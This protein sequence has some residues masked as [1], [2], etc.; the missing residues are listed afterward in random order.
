[1]SA[2]T[3]WEQETSPFHPGEITFQERVG[4]RDQMELSG[5][6][7]IRPYMPQQHRDF[8]T[9]LP[10]IAVGSVDADGWPWASLLVGK[11]GF[12]RSP[13]DRALELDAAPLPGDP[14]AGSLNPGAPLGLLGIELSTRRRNRLNVRVA[15]TADGLLR[16]AVDQSFGNC[17][18]YI[19]TRDYDFVRDPRQSGTPAAPERFASFDDATSDLIRNA[20][21]FF[22]ASY[23]EAGGHS[24]IDGADVSHRGGRPGFVRV[25]GNTLTIPDFAG[26]NHF[27]TLGNFLLNPK[28]GLLFM[29]F[30]NGDLVFLTGTVEIIHDG[31][32][33]DAFMGAER[34]WQF[35]LDHG[36]RLA[37]ALPI[38]WTLNDFSPNSLI[39]GTWGE[40]EAALAAEAKREAWRPYRVVRTED[41]SSVIRSFYLEPEDG[42]G[43][44]PHEAGQYLTVRVTPEDADKPVIRTYTLS[45]S[46]ADNHYRIS[47]KREE[48]GWIS[49]HLHAALKTGA[50]IEAKA[51]RGDFWL[52]ASVDRPAVLIAGGVGV[53]P[54]ISMA[55]HAATEGLRTRHYRPL[56]IL[57][58][59]QTTGQ[60][61]FHE[62]FQSLAEASDGALRYVSLI[63]RPE[64][65]EEAGIDFD[66]AG[67]IGRDVLRQHLALDN[68]DFFLCGPGGFMQAA[69]DAIR[70]LGVRDARIHAEAFGP[71]SLER[72]PD[73]DAAPVVEQ[74]P[75][76]KQATVTFAKSGF[77]QTWTPEDGTLLEFAEAHGLTPEHSC[78]SGACGACVVPMLSGK[79]TYRNTVTAPRGEGEV[80][81]CSAVPAAGA[82]TMTLYL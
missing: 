9:Q 72:R 75:E 71:A 36:I 13:D 14:L 22:V 41:E 51:P 18:Q 21:T 57:H 68:Y 8:F 20:D 40:T 74:P 2:L 49:R 17:P 24:A 82:D 46:P 23:L 31:P 19:Q 81:I 80:L 30:E 7:V 61:A 25:A 42:D 1:M 38:R 28:A 44:L 10:F 73:A 3:G 79:E 48:D 66:A 53:T 16:F 50:S 11:P 65:G 26:N 52:D 5:R 64:E 43:L 34:A 54:M 59:A 6:R 47:V 37:D 29:D 33:V 15:G 35:T 77:E 69:Y 56:T 39:S 76:A 60:R 70:A 58:A 78:R 4:K 62:T 27:N 45:S 67:R 63:S 12:I 32:E 55:R